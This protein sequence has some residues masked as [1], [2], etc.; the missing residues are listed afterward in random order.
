M[1]ITTNVK[2]SVI[3]SIFWWLGLM[4]K[5]AR[6]YNTPVFL[7]S[8]SQV[9][10]A[11]IPKVHQARG[12]MTRWRGKR[13]GEGRWF[14]SLKISPPW[15]SSWEALEETCFRENVDLEKKGNLK[16]GS[17][18]IKARHLAGGVDGFSS[19][20]AGAI[21]WGNLTTNLETPCGVVQSS[22]CQ[23]TPSGEPSITE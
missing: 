1:F 18:F 4:S 12:S 19:S 14:T 6:C 21:L 5:Q 7:R 15:F 10:S 9:T 8:L 2:K 16:V 20:T 17:D 22:L 3:T 11:M 23:C 13:V